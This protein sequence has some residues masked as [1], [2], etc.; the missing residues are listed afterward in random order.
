[1]TWPA[2]DRWR[3]PVGDWPPAW[4][5]SWGSDRW[6]LWADLVV[7][8]VAQRLRWIEPSGPDGFWMGSTWGERHAIVHAEVRELADKVEHEPQRVV[9][10]SGFWL[11]DTS[12]TQ[13]FWLQ[14]AEGHANPS[15]FQQGEEAGRRPVEQVSWD[16]VQHW[17]D[18]LARQCPAVVGLVALPTEVQWEYACRAGTT[19]AYW[20]GD[21][22]YP[23]RAGI[24]VQGDRGL[25]EV[26]GAAMPSV[27]YPPNPWG[28]HGMHGNVWEWCE[29]AWLERLDKIGGADPSG[30][31][32]RGGSW[33][34]YPGHAR[35]AFRSRRHRGNRRR[36]L[37][38]RLSLR[39]L[40]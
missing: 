30:R 17:M 39:S 40:G 10:E 31:A 32:V 37:S 16:D 19:T 11:A 1:M 33:L 27:N 34:L 14:V 6:G 13:T 21:E 24:N 18:L 26:K 29:D 12:C 35:S 28:L 38:F 2:A 36:A 23:V 7:G 8:D 20:W 25:D 15:Q 5:S 3:A 9:V 4:A 22:F